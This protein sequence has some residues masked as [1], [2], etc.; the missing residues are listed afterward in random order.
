MFIPQIT[1]LSATHRTLR[2]I[3]NTTLT[4]HNNPTLHS[5]QTPTTTQLFLRTSLSTTAAT[6]WEGVVTVPTLSCHFPT[7]TAQV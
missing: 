3:P 4:D 2:P 7:T 6:P 5:T 1:L